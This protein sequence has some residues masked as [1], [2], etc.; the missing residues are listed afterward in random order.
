MPPQPSELSNTESNLRS[1]GQADI[2]PTLPQTEEKVQNN[3]DIR[4]GP[5]EA[6]TPSKVE[7][8]HREMPVLTPYGNTSPSPIQKVLPRTRLNFAEQPDHE[9]VRR[10]SSRVKKTVQPFQATW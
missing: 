10:R 3:D 9:E 7:I 2:T 4:V 1:T 6:S 5:T 8:E